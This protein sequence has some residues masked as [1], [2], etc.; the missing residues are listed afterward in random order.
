MTAALILMLLPGVRFVAWNYQHV[1]YYPFAISYF[2]INNFNRFPNIIALLSIVVLVML[3]ARTVDP[4]NSKG[5]ARKLMLICMYICISICI[6]ASPL[7]WLIFAGAGG[8]PAI[9]FLGVIVFLLHITTLAL[10]INFKRT[11]AV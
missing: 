11:S 5:D 7:S 2:N 3:I 1:F 8:F 9:T 4:I 10:Q 6:V